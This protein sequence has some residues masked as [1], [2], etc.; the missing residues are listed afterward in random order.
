MILLLGTLSA[1]AG[2][3]NDSRSLPLPEKNTDL[4]VMPLDQY[5]LSTTDTISRDYAENLLI[6][7]CMAKEGYDFPVPWR[8]L[9]A[10]QGPSFNAA[11]VRL[12]TVELASKYG[13]EIA[14]NL[15]PSAAAWKEIVANAPTMSDDE[16]AVFS[17]CLAGSRK[18]VHLPP[19]YVQTANTF[20]NDAI[21]NAEQT[22]G[23]K[24]TISAWKTCMRPQGISDL[25]DSPLQMPP[26]SLSD[27]YG[28]DQDGGGGDASA[29]EV[30]MAVADA[31]CQASSGYRQALYDAEWDLQV[32]TLRSN[33]DDLLRGY[34]ALQKLRSE[35]V[36]V[37][38]EHA[39]AH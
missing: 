7:P 24:S 12:F 39:P 3:N 36:T 14:P 10:L 11:G 4:W 6:S 31:K 26:P 1:C 22:A 13:Y 29:E 9:D 32:Q 35:V 25:P 19:D 2:E 21:T 20:S 5:V 15:D 18:T 8:N 17:S 30:A 23:V 33:A 38:A 37:V 16:Q 28:L 34:S 27:E